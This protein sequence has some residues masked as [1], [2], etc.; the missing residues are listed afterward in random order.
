MIGRKKDAIKQTKQDADK[1][2]RK[3]YGIEPFYKKNDHYDKY[4]D[5]ALGT[6]C[7]YDSDSSSC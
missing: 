3:Q 4:I 6:V 2:F 5:V 7:E 1:L